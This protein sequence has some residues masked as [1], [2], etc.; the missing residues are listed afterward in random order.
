MALF[1]VLLAIVALILILRYR[2]VP[3]PVPERKPPPVVQER[4]AALIAIV[5]DDMGYQMKPLEE[6]AGLGV[7]LTVAVL[8]H[9]KHSQDVAERAHLEGIEVLLH[10][11]MEPKQLS[12]HDPGRGALYTTM[13]DDQIGQTLAQNL[14]AVPHIVGVNNHMGSRFTEVE[15]KMRPVL[16]LLKR[17]GLFFLDSRTTPNSVAERLGRELGLAV[18]SRDIFL[19]NVRT[20]EYIRARIE[21]LTAIARER[22]SAIAIGHPYPETIATLKEVIGSLQKEGFKLVRVSELTREKNKRR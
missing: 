11:P 7:P 16:R 13:A 14:M 17:Q 12:R 6:I 2:P 4:P 3:P 1:F 8:P 9:L 10:L 5:I 19:D 15:Q 22:G 18:A 21:E 20:K